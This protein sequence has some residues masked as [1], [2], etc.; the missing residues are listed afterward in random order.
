[1]IDRGAIDSCNDSATLF[2]RDRDNNDR[3]CFI[4]RAIGSDRSGIAFTHLRNQMVSER[5]G[6]DLPATGL[7]HNCRA[8]SIRDAQIEPERSRSQDVLKVLT[9]HRGL[10]V[11]VTR[12]RRD[13]IQRPLLIDEPTFER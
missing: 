8:C 3:P 9:N 7:R 12:Q 5:V 13:R 10:R 11:L 1:M 6:Q 2:S 4:Y